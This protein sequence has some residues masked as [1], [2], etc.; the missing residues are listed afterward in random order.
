M[1]HLFNYE[2]EITSVV[3]LQMV[4]DTNLGYFKQKRFTGKTEAPQRT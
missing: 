1:R 2:N 3:M 4:P